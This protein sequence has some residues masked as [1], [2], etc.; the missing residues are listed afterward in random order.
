MTILYILLAI[1]LLGVLIMVHEFGHFSAARLCDI[2]VKEFSIG[3]GPKVVQWHSKKHETVFSL[4]P[5]PL[6][7]Y[8][9]FYGDTDD[10]PKGEKKDDLRNLNNASVWKRMLTIV[11]G[12]L[13][14]FVL[15]FVVAVVL[16]A[17][18][19]VS[20]S[21][22][23]IAS[24]EDGQPA[25]AAGLLAGDVFVSINGVELENQTVSDATAAID[26]IPAGE[27][28]NMVVERAGERLTFDVAPF[29]DSAEQRYRIGIM[30]QQGYQPLTGG[31]IIPAAWETCVD[32]G[33][34]IVT[35]LGKLFTT[36]EGLNET[37]GPVRIVQMVAEE[38]KKGGLEM[39]MFL[40]VFISINL[41]L[42]N[43]LPIP[44]LDGSRIV[45]LIIEAIRRK[46][47]SQNIEAVVHLCGY[48]FLFG[49]MIFFTFRDVLHI[50]GA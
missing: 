36:G 30:I 20:V 49:V 1:V 40:M 34:A 9:M 38:T 33:S 14:N 25:Q 43:L 3:F 8:C 15:A 26:R 44:G 18:Y 31:Q 6:G 4:R 21:T 41:G 48:V 45:F 47:V 23:F 28:L 2:A 42:M 37:G 19:G 32:A 22:P 17:S 24:V 35:A 16:M 12:P 27:S 7:G 29:Y 50:F 5:I 11:S 13:M 46:P 39:F 10:D